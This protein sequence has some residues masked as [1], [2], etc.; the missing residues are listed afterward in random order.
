MAN[1]K[2]LDNLLDEGDLLYCEVENCP[3]VENGGQEIKNFWEINRRY[4]LNNIIFL[5]L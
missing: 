3:E 5:E 1:K 2:L 4:F